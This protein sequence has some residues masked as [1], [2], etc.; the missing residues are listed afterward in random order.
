MLCPEPLTKHSRTLLAVLALLGLFSTGCAARVTTRSYVYTEPVVVAEP[1]QLVYVSPGFYVVRDYNEAVYYSDGYYWCHR[2]GVWYQTAYWGDPW[3]NVHVSVVP[4]VF[5]HAHHHTYVHYHGAA[6]APVY[7][8]PARNY[9]AASPGAV[10]AADHRSPP[11][12]PGHGPSAIRRSGPAAAPA[13][14]PAS[15]HMTQAS[16]SRP[17][18]QVSGG[19]ASHSHAASRGAGAAQPVSAGR[20]DPPSPDHSRAQAH[21]SAPSRSQ[22]APRKASAPAAPA[23]PRASTPARKQPAASPAPAKPKTR[24]SSDS[25]SRS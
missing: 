22:P 14:A 16:T 19:G 1:V 12:P 3:V 18:P 11:P 6:G 2:G 13:H 20:A 17:T 23:A 25:P 8:A 21:S 4:A 7:Q 9:H 15:G 10:A 5:V 24:K